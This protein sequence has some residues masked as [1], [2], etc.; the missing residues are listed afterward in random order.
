[1]E[2]GARTTAQSVSSTNPLLTMTGE[3]VCTEAALFATRNGLSEYEQIFCRGGLVAKAQSS[4][5]SVENIYCL[6]DE[7]RAA[8]RFEE[9]HKWKSC[10]WMLYALCALC[11][12][13]AIV[14]G[15]DQTVINGAQV[16]KVGF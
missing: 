8:L 6:T 9:A 13:C 3:E 15:M 7:D 10:P 14:Q 2:V 4:F 5:E 16:S 11:A 1:M 12:G